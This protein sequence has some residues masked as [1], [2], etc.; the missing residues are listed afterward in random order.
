LLKRHAVLESWA[1]VIGLAVGVGALVPI[2]MWKDKNGVRVAAVTAIVVLSISVLLIF[3][4][5]FNDDQT[6]RRQVE[7]LKQKFT[8]QLKKNGPQTFDEMFENLH[9]PEYSAA[10]TAIDELYDGGVVEDE[11]AT[12]T[13]EGGVKHTVHVYHLTKPGEG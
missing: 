1:T 13:G 6:E 10:A 2:F 7:F 12:V 9:Y 4:K 3:F 11:N 8:A 5:H